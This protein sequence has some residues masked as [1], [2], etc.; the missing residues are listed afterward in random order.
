MKNILNNKIFLILLIFVLLVCTF[1]NSSYAVDVSE[2]NK[3]SFDDDILSALSNIPEL[4]NTPN[5]YYYFLRKNY[6]YIDVYVISKSEYPDFK[7]YIDFSRELTQSVH[8]YYYY[9][10]YFSVDNFHAL[11]YS[12]NS[13]TKTFELTPYDLTRGRITYRF[14]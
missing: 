6:N 7:V 3:V 4:K 13:D 1:F 9:E 8:D 5:D 2:L 10:A 14:K 12:Y 11:F